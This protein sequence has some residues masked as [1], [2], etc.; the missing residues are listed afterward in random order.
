MYEPLLT[1]W[2]IL[3]VKWRNLDETKIPRPVGRP[4]PSY[5]SLSS[6][7]YF[8]RMIGI[9]KICFYYTFLYVAPG[10]TLPLRRGI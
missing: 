3:D 5:F 2:R 7:F 4:H 9:V 1:H 8:G 10:T 6:P